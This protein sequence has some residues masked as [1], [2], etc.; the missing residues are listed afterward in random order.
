MPE[1]VDLPLR[2]VRLELRPLQEE[3]AE[4]L[5]ALFSDAEAMRYWSEPAW[6]ENHAPAL[7]AHSHVR[8]R[9]GGALCLV[10]APTTDGPIV[11]YV[12]LFSFMAGRAEIGYILARN[13]WGNGLMHEALRALIPYG[14]SKLGLHRI[15]ADID[16]RNE[17][18]ALSLERLGFSREGYLPERWRIGDEICDSVL[19]GLLARN[20]SIFDKA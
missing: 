4:A 18:S 9:E 2:T 17:R 11:G 7:I 1:F 3:D 6:T 20:W 15:E 12:N 10:L 5:F 16:P 8:M 14:F 19:Y 13:A